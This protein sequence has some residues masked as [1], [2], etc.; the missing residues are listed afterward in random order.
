MALFLEY[1]VRGGGGQN[2]GAGERDPAALDKQKEEEH[3]K[4][5]SRKLTLLLGGPHATSK[6]LTRSL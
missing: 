5:R 1:K 6:K 4:I 2:R 3:Y